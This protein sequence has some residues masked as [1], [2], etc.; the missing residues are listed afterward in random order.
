MRRKKAVFKEGGGAKYYDKHGV[1]KET[2]EEPVGMSLEI[3]SA[4]SGIHLNFLLD[5]SGLL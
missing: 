5:E 4:A 3:G 2:I 1:L